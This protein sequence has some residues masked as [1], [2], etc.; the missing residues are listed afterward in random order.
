MIELKTAVLLAA[1]VKIGAII[2]GAD[3]KDSDL[4][5]NLEE[6]SVL[7]FRFRMICL[8]FMVI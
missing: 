3:D 2:G 1:S 5:M 4:F 8:I 7:H 6:T